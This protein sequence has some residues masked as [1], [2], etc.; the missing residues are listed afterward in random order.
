MHEVKTSARFLLLQYRIMLNGF[1]YAMFGVPTSDLETVW[2]NECTTPPA[3]GHLPLLFQSPEP[4][5]WSVSIGTFVRARFTS[6][7]TCLL[8]VHVL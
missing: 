4:S 6:S 2:K 3:L 5:T 8:L 1:G 7:M